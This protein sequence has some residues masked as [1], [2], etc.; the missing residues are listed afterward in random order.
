MN[1]AELIEKHKKS[2]DYT[3]SASRGQYKHLMYCP[4]TG[5]GLYD[6]FRGNRWLRNRIQIFKQF[7][8]PSLQ[9][10]TCQDFTL[11]IS[12]R[13]DERYNSIVKDFVEYLKTTGLDVIHTFSGVCF[14]DDKYPDKEAR[15]RLV[16]AIHG[17]MIELV[18]ATE[19]KTGYEWVLMTIQPSDDC[20]HKESVKGIQAVFK[21]I[22]TI[23]AFGFERGYLMNYQTKEVA[24]WSPKTNP[25]FYTIKFPR[26]AFINPLEHVEY[27][28]LKK[29]VGNYKKG[30]P[31]P[32]HEYVEH[33]LRYGKVKDRGFL[34]GTHGENI[35][36]IWNHPYKEPLKNR[37]SDLVLQDFGLDKVEPLK[38]PFSLRRK[39]FSNL[40]HKMQRKLRYWAGEK[41]WILKPLFSLLYNGIRG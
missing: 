29:D 24:E 7:V 14:Y 25:P 10:Q 1:N 15:I 26:H 22:P 32:S 18:N 5:L 20:Y 33:C 23:Q 11:W 28:A 30:T 39:I 19:G 37:L 6:G 13:P 21:E 38:L 8:I 41:N 36:T 17:A 40:P 2:A 35:S 31:L 34:V 16:S 27:T 3:N 12:W 4:F 9:A